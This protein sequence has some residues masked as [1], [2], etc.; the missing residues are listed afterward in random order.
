MTAP[1][2]SPEM[3]SRLF[4][5]VKTRRGS[6]YFV[7]LRN[8]YSPSRSLPLKRRTTPS[9]GVIGTGSFASS[10]RAVWSRDANNRAGSIPRANQRMVE[11]LERNVG[12]SDPGAHDRSALT[13]STIN[14]EFGAFLLQGL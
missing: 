11:F 13:S 8:V 1:S 9:A 7:S 2:P 14:L 10:P 5:T 4:S 3:C 6:L 12:A